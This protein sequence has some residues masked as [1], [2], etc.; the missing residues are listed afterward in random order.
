MLATLRNKLPSGISIAAPSARRVV[1]FIFP[2]FLI[3]F[4]E[5]AVHLEWLPPS[6]FAAPSAVVRYLFSPALLRDLGWTCLRLA[7][8]IAIGA[9]LGMLTGLLLA[10]NKPCDLLFSS[11]V[12]FAAPIPI[13][14]WLP[15]LVIAFGLGE[16]TKFAFVATGAF[17][18]VHIHCYHAVQ[19]IDRHVDELTRIY[20]KGFWKRIRD[21]ILPAS[22][23]SILVAIRIAVALGWVVVALAEYNMQ[24]RSHAGIGCFILLS[25]S[26][27]RV[28]QK[29]AGIVL[30]G[31]CG[32]LI[33]RGIYM[34]D[35]H[36]RRWAD[37]S[38]LPL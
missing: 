16:V 25:E 26:L 2:V 10:Q 4:W 30:L 7:G 27:G 32:A 37:N 21:V 12:Q 15:F 14:I 29:F 31:L 33:D 20:Q 24:D 36:L 34:T 13:V 22:M 28:E 3:L 19:N 11:T 38:T 23:G 17:F 18:L 35:K 9:T 8:G 1:P 5:V 6:E